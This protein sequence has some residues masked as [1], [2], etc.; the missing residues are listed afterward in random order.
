MLD[1]VLEG[2][3]EVVG[4]TRVALVVG[5]DGVIVASAGE[6]AGPGWDLVAACWADLERRARLANTETGLG[7]PAELVMTSSEA[8][9]AMRLVT[10]EYALLLVLG[11]GGSLG[12]ARYELRKAAAKVRP[13]LEA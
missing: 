12:R 5:T 2:L 4:G 10:R 6:S 1:E 3:V 9:V 7:E 8:T 11:A 13:E